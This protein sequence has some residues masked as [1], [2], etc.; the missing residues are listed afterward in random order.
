MALFQQ[1][2]QVFRKA[3]FDM[4]RHKLLFFGRNLIP[5]LELFTLICM[6]SIVPVDWLPAYKA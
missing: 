1:A 6:E 5:S 2:I 3:D 4:V